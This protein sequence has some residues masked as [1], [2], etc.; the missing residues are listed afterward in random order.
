M[1]AAR[2]PTTP[3]TAV[4]LRRWLCGWLVLLTITQT[5]GSALAGLQGTWHR[6]RP[7]LQTAAAPSTP[8]VRWRHAET[9][10]AA[11]AHAQMHASGEAH[12]HPATDD[13]VL[14]LGSDAASDAVAQLAAAVAP[15]A[16]A[17]WSPY[18][19][20]HHAQAGTAGWAPT[21]RSI[22]PPLRPPR[23]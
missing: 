17:R 4:S 2:R 18:D 20:A 6:H 3:P 23:G 9:V 22:A 7:A 10:R 14:P 1:Q 8:L 16:D 21:T 12:D 19:R 13:S 5:L 11:D 15:G